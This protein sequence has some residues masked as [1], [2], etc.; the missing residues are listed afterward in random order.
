MVGR[1]AAL[2]QRAAALRDAGPGARWR[3]R[4]RL[5]ASGVAAAVGYGWFATPF[6]LTGL[7]GIA[8]P[9]GIAKAASWSDW[10]W[11][12]VSGAAFLLCAAAAGALA[13]LRLPPI[14]GHELSRS[15]VPALFTEVD[16]LCRFYGVPPVDRICLS[17]D[18]A[19]ELLA[20]PRWGLPFAMQQTLRIGLPLLLTLSPVQCRVQLARRI[21]QG[22]LRHNRWSGRL[23]TLRH[24]WG[25]YRLAGPPAPAA[26]ATRAAF[27]LFVP[28]YLA[29]SRGVARD[30][31][32]EADRYALDLLNHED[33][34]EGLGAAIVAERF[35]RERFWPK[36][37]SLAA[38]ADTTAPPPYDSMNRVYRRGLKAEDARRWL[39]EAMEAPGTP[40]LPPLR[41]RLH[42]LG[43]DTPVPPRA[44]EG[45]AAAA[46]FGDALPAVI[47]RF[48]RR[49][50]RRRAAAAP[51]PASTPAAGLKP[52]G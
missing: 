28:A 8:L 35:L 1:F 46:L 13:R 4:L 29:L 14:A 50:Q 31:E 37:Q 24:I 44:A 3:R 18:F 23:S 51:R 26:L 6:V 17:E 41:E 47:E 11:V 40:L 34:V 49:W 16:E 39:A 9:A 33:V 12:A 48:D 21:G 30:D 25:Q 10:L 15:Q 42:R 52:T 45:S 2:R 5:A 27:R 7:L 22:S 38:R 32:L 20:R 43:H 36:L 19:V